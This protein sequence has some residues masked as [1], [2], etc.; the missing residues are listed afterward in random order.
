M[1]MRAP[2]TPLRIG[3]RLLRLVALICVGEASFGE[4]TAV[5]VGSAVESVW[6]SRAMRSAVVILKVSRSVTFS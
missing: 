3:V 2:K 4:E 6:F 1:R 5:G